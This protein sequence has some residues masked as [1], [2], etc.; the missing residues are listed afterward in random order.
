MSEINS[1]ADKLL[2]RIALEEKYVVL[3]K[4]CCK[5]IFDPNKTTNQVY[6][7]DKCPYCTLPGKK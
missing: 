1:A 4:H 7:K 3:C 5:K 6:Y 2:W